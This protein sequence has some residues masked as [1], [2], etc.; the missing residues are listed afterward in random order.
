MRNPTHS[1]LNDST[2]GNKHPSYLPP[3]NYILGLAFKALCV[4]SVSRT[5][6]SHWEN[7]TNEAFQNHVK[8]MVNRFHYSNLTVSLI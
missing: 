6:L 1:H 3:K 8:V 2:T 5:D 7:T 4:V